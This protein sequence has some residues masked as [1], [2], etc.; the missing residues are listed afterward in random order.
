LVKRRFQVQLYVWRMLVFIT[1]LAQLRLM[2]K[3]AIN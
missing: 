3:L 2:W 1:L